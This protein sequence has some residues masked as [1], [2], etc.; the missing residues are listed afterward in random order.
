M[1]LSQIIKCAFGNQ[2][3]CFYALAKFRCR[4]PQNHQSVPCS[5]SATIDVQLFD[6]HHIIADLA[7]RFGGQIAFFPALRET[8]GLSYRAEP[9]LPTAE[10]TTGRAAAPGEEAVVL[11]A[12]FAV[13]ERGSR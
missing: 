1:L 10:S 4:L 5:M 13:G 2:I 3:W 6:L 12:G 7:G 8:A 11:K 9:V